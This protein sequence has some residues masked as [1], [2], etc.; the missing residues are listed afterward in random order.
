[1]WTLTGFADE[2]S[3][4]LNEQLDTL[5]SEKMRY[6]E[7]RA[8]WKKNVL[9]LSDEEIDKVKSELDARGIGV[10]AIGSP[11]GKIPI[12]DDFAP[13]KERFE[14]AI[15]CAKRLGTR[16]IRIFSF[17]VP[18]GEAEK[19]RTEVMDRLKALA[20]RAAQE[21]II[22]LHENEKEIYGDTPERC[23]DIV[24][25]VNSPNLRVTWDP[26]NFVQVGVK[27]P[28]TA[29]YE[30]LRPYIEYVHVKDALFESGQNVPAGEGH[31]QIPETI[32][33]LRD[34]NFS[35]F[36]SLEPH[37]RAAGTYSGFSGPDLFKKA[38]QAFKKIL[39]EANIAWQ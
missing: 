28:H 25:T 33:A 14:R 15:W 38:A 12:T 6:L 7:F 18:E 21:D 10:S 11:I 3:P 30:M 2:I 22:L 27:E 34:S 16:Y 19:H 39:E 31:G 32:K 4:D 5:E 8:V 20:E 23:L 26:A 13:H 17:F 29:G 9:D 24:E 1:M 35:G 37:L 36:F